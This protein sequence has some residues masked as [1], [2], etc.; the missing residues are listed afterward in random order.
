MKSPIHWPNYSPQLT[1]RNLIV[2]TG[3]MILLV[4]LIQGDVDFNTSDEGFLW[5][6]TIRTALGEVPMRDF[7]SYEPG[8]YYWGALWFRLLRNDGILAL[9]ASQAALEFIGLFLALLL[10][11]RLV[12][13]WIALA[14]AAAIL[15]RWMVPTWKIYEPVIEIGAIYVAVLV[16]EKPSFN[17]YFLAGIFTGLAGFFGR[18][19][20]FYCGVAFVFLTIFL[21]WKTDKRVLLERFGA[22]A[23]G[24]IIGYAPMLFMFAFVPGFFDQFKQDI[25]FNLHYGTNLPIPVPFPWRLSFEGVETR[26]AISRIFT[27]LLFIAFPAFYVFALVRLLLFKRKVPLHPVF[28]AATFVG[29]MYLHYTF[30]RPIHYY[31]KWTSPPFIL[32]VIATAASWSKPPSR[33]LTIALWSI[34]AIFTLGALELSDENHFTVKLKAFTKATLM[35]RQGG[36]FN[37]AMKVRGFEKT[38]V[39]GDNLWISTATAPV[40]NYVT[41]MDRELSQTTHDFFGAPYSAGL[42]AVLRKRSPIREIYFLFPSPLDKQQKMV[43]GLQGSEVNWAWICHYYADERPELSFE[44]THSLVWQYFVAN[45]ETI[46]TEE[47]RKIHPRCELMRRRVPHANQTQLFR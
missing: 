31:L 19:H 46:Q 13:N 21:G 12:S 16:I 33:R 36:D 23:V 24:V 37:E 18:N 32:G 5:Y 10:L 9:R 45:F 38:N 17:R 7:Q 47:T 26:E 8:R 42:Y 4:Y 1:T 22:L 25:V 14:F 34:L 3:L 15:V 29:A 40:I 6:G 41:A 39:G 28:I 27:G 43:Q 30:D 11:R 44:N 20:G 2:L 35:R